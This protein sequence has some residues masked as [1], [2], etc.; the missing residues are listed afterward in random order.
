M[1]NRNGKHKRDAAPTEVVGLWTGVIRFVRGNANA[2][3]RNSPRIVARRRKM[4]GRKKFYIHERERERKRGIDGEMH[5]RWN[6]S[7]R[8]KLH[9]AKARRGE[10]KA[11]KKERNVDWSGGGYLPTRFR[12]HR[13]DV[14]DVHSLTGPS[15]SKHTFPR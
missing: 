15:A 5:R 3:A 2:A 10:E 12:L 9:Y 13:D 1:R 6:N 11:K 4:N 7:P 14:G 8:P